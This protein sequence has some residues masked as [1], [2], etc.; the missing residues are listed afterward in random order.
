MNTYNNIQF[1]MKF[2]GRITVDVNDL[3]SINRIIYTPISVSKC[4]L[5]YLIA[6]KKP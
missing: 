5:V 4:L 3:R 1:G 6:K 2:V